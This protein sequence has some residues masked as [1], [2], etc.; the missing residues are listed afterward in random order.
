LKDELG[1]HISFIGKYKQWIAIK[2]L[3]LESV[4][5]YEVSAVL[6]SANHTMINKS[7]DFADLKKNDAVVD[8][9]CK[10]KRK[11]YGNV[12][13]A[14]K[15]L[16]PKLSGT[17]DDAYVVC[18]VLETLGFKP[19]ASPDMLTAA[20]PDIKPPKVKGRKPKG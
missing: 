1:D 14:L 8:S 19:Y 7:F 9:I 13:Q 3:G 18:K 2:K 15:D 16:T 17:S 11:S 10:G 12:A 5:D 4:Q 20:H 6:A